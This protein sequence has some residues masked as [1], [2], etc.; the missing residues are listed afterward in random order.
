MSVVGGGE[1]RSVRRKQREGVREVAAV[2][3]QRVCGRVVFRSGA[4]MELEPAQVEG[5]KATT[6]SAGRLMLV[7]MKPTRG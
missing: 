1:V 2:H 6:F 4:C 3:C 5:E 7:T